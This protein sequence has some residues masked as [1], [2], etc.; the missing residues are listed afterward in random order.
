MNL[1]EM[2]LAWFVLERFAPESASNQG[3][4]VAVHSIRKGVG[5]TEMTLIG[6]QYTIV[7]G[8]EEMWCNNEAYI[9]VELLI[10]QPK[11]FGF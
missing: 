1:L 10:Y 5:L 11:L 8:K 2:V 6:Y 7:A 9:Y 3:V 4:K